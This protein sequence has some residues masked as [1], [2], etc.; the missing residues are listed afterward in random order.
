MFVLKDL[1]KLKSW[2]F[3]FIMWYTYESNYEIGVEYDPNTFLQAIR[4]G[5]SKLWYDVIND[6]MKSMPDN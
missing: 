5:K 3:L 6:E 1:L 4:S 2:Q